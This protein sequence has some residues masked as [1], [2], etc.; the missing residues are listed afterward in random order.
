MLGLHFEAQKLVHREEPLC[1]SQDVDTPQSRPTLAQCAE[2]ARPPKHDSASFGKGHIE[3][4]RLSPAESL[5]SEMSFPAQILAP[6]I[7]FPLRPPTSN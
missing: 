7:A 3:M 6:N 5:L 4:G 1:H 2:L